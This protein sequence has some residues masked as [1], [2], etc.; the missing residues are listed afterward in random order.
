MTKTNNS[1]QKRFNRRAHEA[2]EQVKMIERDKEMEN[3][4]PLPIDEIP[5]NDG[6]VLVIARALRYEIA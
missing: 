1:I 3:V 5:K 6:Q 2:I 4:V